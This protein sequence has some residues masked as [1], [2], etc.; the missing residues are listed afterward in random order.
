MTDCQSGINGGITDI[1]IDGEPQI[2]FAVRMVKRYLSEKGAESVGVRR[3]HYY[4]VSLP[5]SE[6]MIRGKKRGEI[7]PYFNSKNEYIHLSELL[8]EA[9]T[10]GLIDPSWIIDEKNT[11]LIEMPQREE[12]FTGWG[13]ETA[14]IE[15]LPE[16]VTDE[17]PEWSEW[18]NRVCFYPTVYPSKFTHQSHRIVVAIEKATSKTRLREICEYHGADL[19]VFTGQPSVT[20]IYDVIRRAQNEAKPILLLYISDLDCGG[21]DMP[22]AFF[23]RINEIYPRE[24]HRMVRVALTREQARKYNLPPAFDPDDKGYQKLQKDRFIRE[25]GGHECIELDALDE[26]ILLEF[27]KIS[28]TEIFRAR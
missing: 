9:R 1:P 27:L 16:L 22:S 6:R 15:R 25:S 20:R 19:L 14:D 3:L 26:N 10:K 11:P 12:I 7:R 8:V 13:I 28:A 18:L 4:I 5:E 2:D 23:N 24:D 17:F 21:W